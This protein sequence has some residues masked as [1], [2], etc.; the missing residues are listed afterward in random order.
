[1]KNN[2]RKLRAGLLRSRLR[3]LRPMMSARKASGGRA[4]FV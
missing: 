2:V 3:N 4:L 1:M